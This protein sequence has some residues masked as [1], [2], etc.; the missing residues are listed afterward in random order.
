VKNI[1]WKKIEEDDFIAE[2]F[3]GEKTIGKVGINFWEINFEELI[4][5]IDETVD[6]KIVSKY[7]KINRDVAFFVP[8]EFS[9]EE[10][11]DLIKK[12]LPQEAR[13]LKIFDIYNDV[14]NE[15]KSFAFRI[16]FQS[17]E[18]TLSDEFANGEMEKVYE[19]LKK[20][21]FEIR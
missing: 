21:N 13:E 19:I 7:P 12:V 2:I 3:C 8:T 10:A 6:Y 1:S 11:T 5:C 20:N 14:E 9:V 16:I 17:D 18:K 15:K 4:S